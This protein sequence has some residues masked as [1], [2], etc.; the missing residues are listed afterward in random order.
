M[1]VYIETYGCAYAQAESEMIAGMLS[2][3]GAIIVKSPEIADVIILVTCHVKETTEKKIL[4]RIKQLGENYSEKSLI[5]YGCLAQAYPEKI[6]DANSQASLVGNFSIH[7]IPEAVKKALEGKRV[8]YL[9][10]KVKP[11]LGIPRIKK[12]PVIG[13]VPI[14]EGCA[15]NCAYCSTKF[16]RGRIIS[17]PKE[18]IVKEICSLLNTGVKEIWLT[19]QDTGAYGIDISSNLPELLKEVS[20][21]QGKFFVRVGMLNPM[22]ARK[23]LDKLL[24]AY[25]SEKIYKFL[26]IPVQSGSNKILELMK[27]A[28]NVSDFIEIIERFRERFPRIQIW[29][30]IIVGYPS[31]SEEDFEQTKSLLKE[32]EPDWVNISRF[33]L[34]SGTEAAKMKQIPTDI[35]K[36]RSRELSE[37]VR[38]I[39]EKVNE[40]WKNWEGEVLVSEKGKEGWIGRNFAYKPVVIKSGENLL[41]KFVRV[42]IYK[43]KNVLFAKLKD[44][45]E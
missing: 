34:R 28:Y 42:K 45:W 43:T 31:E 16:S 25:E 3:A 24:E 20:K 7:E 39:V 18:L 33:S 27:R 13:I 4:F 32:I 23:Y 35:K 38:K 26:H 17:Y 10:K 36:E 9:E 44:E 29:T 41:G 40:K 14:A 21:I 37:L 2:K 11:K 12:N 1:Q 19:A 5:V 30:D 6:L 8:E 15:G 22:H